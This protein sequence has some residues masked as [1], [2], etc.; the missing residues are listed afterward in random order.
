MLK[1]EKIIKY[2]KALFENSTSAW[3]SSKFIRST[4]K[5]KIGNEKN[6]FKGIKLRI[7]ETKKKCGIK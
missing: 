6:K 5:I 3:S 1:R 7:P 2:Q 4:Y